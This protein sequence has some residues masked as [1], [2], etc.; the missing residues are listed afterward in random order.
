MHF[1]AVVAQQT[2]PGGGD[3][4]GPGAGGM[5]LDVLI[6]MLVP[7]VIIFWLMSRSQKKRDQ[8]R[9]DMLAK[10][11]KGDHVVTVGG[12]HGDVVRL[13]EKEVVLLVDK[14]KNVELRFQR[15][16]IAGI[17]G[18]KGDAEQSAPAPQ[19]GGSKA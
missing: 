15:S 1:T 14:S 10:I 5:Q 4:K 8:E 9:K 7:I 2:A 16:A 11:A 12:L 17:S 18:A 13:G 3:Q 19:E 6:L